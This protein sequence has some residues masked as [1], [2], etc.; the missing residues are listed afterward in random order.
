MTYTSYGVCI[1]VEMRIH[2]GKNLAFN[3]P[4]FGTLTIDRA[5]PNPKDIITLSEA[6]LVDIDLGKSQSEH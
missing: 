3:W 6:A 1:G 5:E 2:G 4:R